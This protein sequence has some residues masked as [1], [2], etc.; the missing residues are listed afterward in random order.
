MRRNLQEGELYQV[1][2]IRFYALTIIRAYYMKVRVQSVAAYH[3]LSDTTVELFIKRL[4][5]VWP[6]MDLDAQITFY[7]FCVIKGG[8][9]LHTST[10]TQYSFVPK[11]VHDIMKKSIKNCCSSQTN[12]PSMIF[13]HTTLIVR[14]FFGQI[15]VSY[16]HAWHLLLLAYFLYPRKNRSTCVQFYVHQGLYQNRSYAR[17]YCKD[18]GK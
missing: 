4:F 2:K 17:N 18:F 14:A 16:L 9:V 11:V 8:C 10:Q 7:T 15:P 12:R 5:K 13:A 1:Y 3:R 6:C